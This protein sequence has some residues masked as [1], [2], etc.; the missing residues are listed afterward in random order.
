VTDPPDP[1]DQ[2]AHAGGGSIHPDIDWQAGL[3]AGKVLR[4]VMTLAEACEE[5]AGWQAETIA[6]DGRWRAVEPR[7]LIVTHMLNRL[8]ARGD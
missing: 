4:R 6:P 2:T 7:A 5:L 1:P 3:L 8:L